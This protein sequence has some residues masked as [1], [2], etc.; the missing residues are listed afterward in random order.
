MHAEWGPF[1]VLYVG[2]TQRT[3]KVHSNSMKLIE[4]NGRD[5]VLQMNLRV[6]TQPAALYGH[7]LVTHS[8]ESQC[9]VR[10]YICFCQTNLLT[11][12]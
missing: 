3:K 8:F 2:L 12:I 5:I 1:H 9:S 7:L 10:K 4:Y 11:V 6:I